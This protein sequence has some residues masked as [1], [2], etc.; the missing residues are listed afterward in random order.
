MNVNFYEFAQIIAYIKRVVK[1]E[2]SSLHL[3]KK[4]IIS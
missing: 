4:L 2:G 1:G 3:T